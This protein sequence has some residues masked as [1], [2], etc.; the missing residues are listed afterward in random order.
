MDTDI[1]QA[2]RTWWDGDAERYHRS[3]ASYLSSFYWCPEM[4]HE[5]DAQL[6]GDVTGATVLELGGGSAPCASW[7]A[8]QGAGFVIS[9]DIS[10]GML[11]RAD[12][13]AG[14]GLV[15]ADA[16]ALPYRDASFDVVF[17]AFGALPFVPD[18]DAVL[19]DVA[20][21]MKPGGRLVFSVNHP[22]RWVFAD[23]P[24]PAGLTAIIPYFE[25]SYLETDD[26]GEVVYAEYHR[27]FGDWVRA[28]NGA[29]LQLLEV[30]EPTWPDDLEETW[31]QWS[32]LRG[33]IFPG[34][35]IFV[36]ELS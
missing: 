25:R 14:V 9:F 2:N 22:M 1:A 30:L 28:I 33:R 31:G 4:L 35:A 5:S 21:V 6:L 32:P 19:R 3:H 27:T 29:G 23:D 12:R 26:A 15:Q 18:V 24:G 34:T 16:Q 36:T 20:R 7:L 17:S 8:G 10:R 11:A 13:E